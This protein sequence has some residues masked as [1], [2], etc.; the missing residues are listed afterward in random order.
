MTARRATI[1]VSL[2]LVTFYIV[3]ARAVL[4][5]SATA[6]E[7]AHLMS[8]YCSAYRQDFRVAMEVPPAWHYLAA[9]PL[10]FHPPVIDEADPHWTNLVNDPTLIWKWCA[11]V[12]YRTPEND[13]VS[14]LDRCR[15]TT[16]LFGVML[17]ALIAGWAGW[18]AGPSASVVAAFLF[19][20]DPNFIGHSALVKNDVA[21]TLFWTLTAVL[22][23]W[24]GIRLTP[25]NVVGVGVACGLAVGT[26]TTGVLVVPLTVILLFLRAMTSEPWATTFGPLLTRGQR[27]LAATGAT[28][29]S[30][31]VCYAMIW[32]MYGFRYSLTPDGNLTMDS[33]VLLKQMAFRDLSAAV[34][35]TPA[36]DRPFTAR[37]Y[38]AWQAP[39]PVRA[40]M[41]CTDLHLLP[42]G[43]LKGMLMIRASTLQRTAYLLGETYHG[44]RWSYFPVAFIVKTPVA[45]LLWCLLGLATL[46]L[47]RARLSMLAPA[48]SIRWVATCVVVPAVLYGLAAGAGGLNIGLRHVFPI[49]PFIFMTLAIATV[50]ALRFWGRSARYLFSVLGAGLLVES[51]AAFPDYIAFFNT[52]AGGS[53][54]GFA[55]LSDSN[56]DWGQDL[57][58]LA[59]WRADHSSGELY[60]S[61]WAPVDPLAYDVHS[62]PISGSVPLGTPILPV[63]R[64]ERPGYVAVSANNLSGVFSTG[65]D[66]AQL[67]PLR[68]ADPIAIVGGTI[69]IFQ[70][71]AP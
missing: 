17:G 21:I 9:A 35:G 46:W 54:G 3:S 31:V 59:H 36:A 71:G 16:L 4:T 48:V 14:M 28:L 34:A 66:N 8:A 12:L 47:L 58:A 10:A 25:W 24:T 63:H 67:E 69:Y 38:A 49:Y 19:C 11:D 57:R 44:S 45:T 52:M 42:D 64:I 13:G 7:P 56:L 30:G 37:E 43:F 1:C 26:K 40:I 65:E 68:H 39:W 15:L 22:L 23:W 33:S 6:D 18:V 62:V 2:L 20:C 5:K 27:L 60:L 50:A 51:V 53:R 41:Q 29:V 61:Y 55:I 32:A 70:V